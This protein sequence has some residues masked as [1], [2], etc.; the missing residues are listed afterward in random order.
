MQFQNWHDLSYYIGVNY[1]LMKSLLT[2]LI[3]CF[4]IFMSAQDSTQVEVVTPKIVAKL[5]HGKTYQ[6]EA[7]SVKFLKVVT[8]SRCPKNV[9]CI[10]AGE[11]EVLVAVFKNGKKFEEKI[12]KITP[13]SH[14]KNNFTS[15]FSSEDFS[16]TAFN[17]LPY[18]VAGSKVKAE[19]YSLQLEIK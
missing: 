2:S 16:I 17:L 14:L 13:T 5:A 3:F 8:D 11:A 6:N 12:L 19:E 18:P 7:I 10:W 1:Y 9:Q 15:I 4:S